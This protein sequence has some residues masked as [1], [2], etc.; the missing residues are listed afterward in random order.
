MQAASDSQDT[1]QSGSIVS[2]AK[3][4]WPKTYDATKGGNVTDLQDDSD[5]QSG[6]DNKSSSNEAASMD[7]DE[8]AGGDESGV[9]DDDDDD[10]DAPGVL[11]ESQITDVDQLTSVYDEENE[12]TQ[13]E[14]EVGNTAGATSE[15]LLIQS[16][17][18]ALA[19]PLEADP[20]L[21]R[22]ALEWS[23][24]SEATL[25]ETLQA[26]EDSK[27]DRIIVTRVDILTT[28]PG[29]EYWRQPIREF[30]TPFGPLS[31]HEMLEHPSLTAH[32][33]RVMSS[34][35]ELEAR[36][37]NKSAFKQNKVW[38]SKT[39]NTREEA[40]LCILARRLYN[41]DPHETGCNTT[42]TGRV[43]TGEHQN[44]G[45]V[46]FICNSD[47]CPGNSENSKEWERP[48]LNA[49][50]A[51]DARRC[52]KREN[53]LENFLRFLASRPLTLDMLWLQEFVYK[54]HMKDASK[55]GQGNMASRT[56]KALEK[57]G[58]TGKASAATP[59]TASK[60]KISS[61]FTPK[62]NSGKKKSK[63]T[64]S[65]EAPGGSSQVRFNLDTPASVAS[66]PRQTLK[67]KSKKKKRAAPD[68]PKSAE[69][70]KLKAQLNTYEGRGEI[71]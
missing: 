5:E 20:D 16:Y 25:E 40:P 53:T 59:T 31:V 64:P 50:F 62:A 68:S 26:L 41:S 15:E 70:K 9:E 55:Q 60:G 61:F 23:E 30:P 46:R 13:T 51:D 34:L 12:Q 54:R 47:G 19:D 2:N 69:I 17:R 58:K 63:K 48:T 67:K 37:R 52:L 65:S 1:I 8:K 11:D 44:R 49:N 10:E 21:L 27:S 6:D 45:V 28:D 66:E 3:E 29:K 35:A 4:T 22:D 71:D 39:P 24:S 33:A 57:A 18:D 38:T 43:N 7:D 32:L 14:E 56:A 36:E 42:M